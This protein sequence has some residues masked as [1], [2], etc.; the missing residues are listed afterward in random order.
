[1][2]VFT[3]P[4]GV[5]PCSHLSHSSPEPLHWKHHDFSHPE[6]NLKCG[7][8]SLPHTYGRS[9]LGIDNKHIAVLRTF[10]LYHIAPPSFGNASYTL[11]T[12]VFHFENLRTS[13]RTDPQLGFSSLSTSLAN[14]SISISFL[15]N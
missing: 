1:M 8:S 10:S 2:I 14:A 7:V 5:V 6:Q 12:T 3:H 9:D 13:V 4:K 15:L 11:G